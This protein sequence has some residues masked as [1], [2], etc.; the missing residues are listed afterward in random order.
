MARAKTSRTV[1][2]DLVCGGIGGHKRTSFV[3]PDSA[4]AEDV[5]RWAAEA[6]RTIVRRTQVGGAGFFMSA[7]LASACVYILLG[8]PGAPLA[9]GSIQVTGWFHLVMWSIGGWGL[10]QALTR[11]RA[12][13]RAVPDPTSAE[14]ALEAFSSVIRAQR[15]RQDASPM[16]GCADLLSPQSVKRLT[17]LSAEGRDPTPADALG[18]LANAWGAVW[19]EADTRLAR[20]QGRRRRTRTKLG[21]PDLTMERQ[22]SGHVVGVIEVPLLLPTRGR[23]PSSARA[24]VRT[25]VHLACRSGRW[26]IEDPIPREAGAAETT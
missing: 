3:S 14:R 19:R 22:H 13:R 6:R 5:D 8:A 11:S 12:V 7:A 25:R 15:D 18:R 10:W 17:E 1:V 26:F 21:P 20:S 16:A 24:F 9:G 2:L 4:G 23:E